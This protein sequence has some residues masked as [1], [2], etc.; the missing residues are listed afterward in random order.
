MRCPYCGTENPGVHRFCGMCGRELEP[1]G[2]LLEEAI[3]EPVSARPAPDQ[4]EA[5]KP[6]PLTPA[7]PAPAYTG[8]IFNLGAPA[9]QRSRNLDYLLEDDEPRSHKGLFL[10]GV[11][12]LVLA[13]SL[14]YLRF[15]QTGIPGFRTSSTPT[16]TAAPNPPPAAATQPDSTPTTTVTASPP[17]AP[18]QPQ[19]S[20]SSTTSAAPP[21]APPPGTATNSPPASAPNS[22]PPAP[23]AQTPDPRVSQPGAAATSDKQD[24]GSATASDKAPTKPEAP[25]AKPA[26]QEPTPAA[27]AAA[28][29]PDVPAA[30]MP[31]KKP[32]KPAA[33]K[34]DDPVLLGEKYLYGRGV[35]Q[36]CEKGLRYVKP[37]A[38]QSNP[39]AMITMGALY[40]TG[41]CL[42]RDLPTA[43]RY[44]AL[45][46]R[47]DPEN[48]ALKQN[49]E[50]VW[51][52]MTQSERQLAIRLTQ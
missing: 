48:S 51:G 45:A 19:A 31:P 18:D 2:V 21:A 28:A 23:S 11:I 50:M 5:P 42:S 46:L 52:Q 47:K 33:A 16:T 44:F 13:L 15:R 37:A 43:Y 3:K 35:P 26:D 40:A 27:E 7:T 14:G 38:E 4:A 34:P 9:E 29:P 6:V 1:E 32:T 17:S 39:K 12:A 49:T 8:G 22:A 30:P 10:L 20:P 41:H 24:N 25:P 36:S